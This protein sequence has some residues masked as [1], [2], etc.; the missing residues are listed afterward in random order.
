VT[1]DRTRFFRIR[2]TV[3]GRDTED[4]Q[5]S[6]LYN[7][8]R[9]RLFTGSRTPSEKPIKPSLT[10]WQAFQL[11]FCRFVSRDIFKFLFV[12]SLHG[13]CLNLRLFS[14]WSCPNERPS[15]PS[16]TKVLSRTFMDNKRSVDNIRTCDASLTQGLTLTLIIFI[17]TNKNYI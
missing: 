14:S 15:S 2:V 4:F 3:L 13:F 7:V 11:L 17:N 12:L 1:S 6:R 8:Q 10:L 5:H 9:R 16:H